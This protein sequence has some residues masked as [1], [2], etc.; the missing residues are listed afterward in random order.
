[1]LND[2]GFNLKNYGELV[3]DM[4]AKASELFGENVNTGSNSAIGIFIRVVAWFLALVYELIQRVYLNGFVDSA[5][6]QSL[7]RLG[8]NYSVT[9]N[10]PAVAQVQITVTG[11]QGYEVEEGTEVETADGVIFMVAESF[12]LTNP[13]M[14]V[15]ENG[16]DIQATDEGDNLLFSGSG[17]AVSEIEDSDANVASHAITVQ[18]EPVEEINAVDNEFAAAGGTALED[19][20]SYRTRIQ[21][22]LVATPGPP[23]DG[24]KTAIANVVGVKQVQ[25]I[26]NNTMEP[27]S[28]GNPPKSIHIYVLGGSSDDIAA[29]I[30]S[31]VAAGIQ[32]YGDQNISVNDMSGN[33][34]DI[35]FSYADVV[36]IF[37]KIQLTTDDTF[38]SDDLVTIQQAVIDYI[39]SLTMGDTIVASFFYK[40]IYATTGVLKATVVVGTSQSNMTDNDITL[41]T[42]QAPTAISANIEVTNNA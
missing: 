26:E 24:M 7:D 33:A 18:T 27:D 19:D 38:S 39:N 25:I 28:Y 20:T 40:S 14:T 5:T 29:A 10:P 35:S 3:D 32:T 11:Q 13:V 42:F 23:I 41:S 37:A 8:A 16:A 6:G 22:A 2:N 1:M 9:R 34:H 12:M 31:S 36:P 21:S 15:D 4:S 17:L 30:L